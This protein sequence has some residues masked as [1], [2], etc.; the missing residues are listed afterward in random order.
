[1]LRSFATQVLP[2]F[3]AKSD[4]GG[5]RAKEA[6]RANLAGEEGWE[7]AVLPDMTDLTELAAY[8]GLLARLRLF[9]KGKRTLT[10]AGGGFT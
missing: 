6:S 8:L 1:V 3:L 9:L 5:K 7:G 10:N 2:V 4:D